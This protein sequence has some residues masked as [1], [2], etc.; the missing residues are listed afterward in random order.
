MQELFEIAIQ[1]YTPISNVLAFNDGEERTIPYYISELFQK[2]KDKQWC[3]I[4]EVRSFLS[5]PYAKVLS[6]EQIGSCRFN[7]KFKIGEDSLFVFEM[8]DKIEKVKCTSEN[9]VY[10]RRYRVGSAITSK[11]NLKY[12][13][14]NLI[15][16]QAETL[17]V[18]VK[19]PFSYNFV[20]FLSRILGPI[21]VF[22]IRLKKIRYE[23]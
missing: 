9:A 12:L 11:P 18:W 21:K 7:P 10:H 22:F 13:I 23:F 20:F 5:I 2:R 8:S 4:N 19:N 14:L 16:I 17:C 1:G 6:R 3:T 15:S